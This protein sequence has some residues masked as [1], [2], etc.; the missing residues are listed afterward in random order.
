MPITIC[1]ETQI[2]QP[3][4]LTLNDIPAGGDDVFYVC[5]DKGIFFMRV[6]GALGDDGCLTATQLDAGKAYIG[7]VNMMSGDVS[8]LDD[9]TV[10]ILVDA[11]ITFT[12]PKEVE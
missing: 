4:V 7:V 5:S 6:T 2:N 3:K 12:L 10:I 8:W 1:D 9:E 11:K